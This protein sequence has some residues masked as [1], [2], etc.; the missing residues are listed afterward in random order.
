MYRT[1]MII[2]ILIKY[3]THG[4]P[5]IGCGYKQAYSLT[6]QPQGPHI[7]TSY[8]GCTGLCKLII[9]TIQNHHYRQSQIYNTLS[10]S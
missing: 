3:D 4:I 10:V 2:L 5:F 7:I 1:I 9:I 8:Q 6:D